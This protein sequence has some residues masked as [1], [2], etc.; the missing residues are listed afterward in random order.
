WPIFTRDWSAIYRFQ[1]DAR[2]ENGQYYGLLQN[3]AS[4]QND[5][6]RGRVLDLDGT[7]QHVWLAPG[8]GEAQT[9]VAVVNWR[10]GGAWQRIFDFGFDPSRTVMLT[11]SA[12][13]VLR[14]DL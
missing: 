4:I 14:C 3:G 12:N 11:P 13:N 10:G 2:D 1:N 6:S 5:P 8:V 9:F 7:N